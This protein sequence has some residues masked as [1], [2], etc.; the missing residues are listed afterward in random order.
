MAARLQ[1]IAS[2]S[3]PTFAKQVD[4]ILVQ[5]HR[6]DVGGV[7]GGVR[8]SGQGVAGANGDVSDDEGGADGDATRDYDD[9]GYQEDEVETEH[10][11]VIQGVD[12]GVTLR[13]EELLCSKYLA[14]VEEACEELQLTRAS[15]ANNSM[16]RQSLQ[17]MAQLMKGKVL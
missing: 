12:A 14:P 2:Q 17:D 10:L 6:T 5:L 11:G 15:V 8:R 3:S 16:V 9:E 13:G 7:T 1:T 4:Y